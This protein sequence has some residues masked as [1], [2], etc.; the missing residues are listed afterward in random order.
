ML[1]RKC[2][3]NLKNL[4]KFVLCVNPTGRGGF[5][6]PGLNAPVLKAG[7]VGSIGRRS[8]SEQQE[9]KAEQG[10]AIKKE[11]ICI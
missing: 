2:F 11:H 5:L 8:E 4:F 6:W 10:A 3:S 7:V 1:H 9:I